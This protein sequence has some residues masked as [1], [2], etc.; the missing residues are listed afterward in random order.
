MQ[1]DWASSFEEDTYAESLGEQP[2]PGRL[3][4]MCPGRG[5]RRGGEPEQP[6]CGPSATVRRLTTYQS[7]GLS[8]YSCPAGSMN[9]CT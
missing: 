5:R 1:S 7:L 3:Q 6:K 8:L 9:C 2:G 4:A